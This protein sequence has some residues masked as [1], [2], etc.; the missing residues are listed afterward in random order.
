VIH[1]R[2]LTLDR[3]GPMM[4]FVRARVQVISVMK[5]QFSA[6]AVATGP[7]SMCGVGSFRVGGEYVFFLDKG[8]NF[9][10]S[11]R[12]PS[13]VTTR[14]TLEALRALGN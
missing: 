11:L 9:V 10:N 7:D 4:G 12:Q 3:S 14:Q 1:A 5:G 2:V 8:S 13:N 6:D